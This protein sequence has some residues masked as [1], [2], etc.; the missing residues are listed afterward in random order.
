[1][2][3]PRAEWGL[4]MRTS[5]T[6]SR[7]N[8]RASRRIYD[9]LFSFA[10]RA[11][12]LSVVR[13]AVSGYSR[14]A[15]SPVAI[16]NS[17]PAGRKSDELSEE[18][19]SREASQSDRREWSNTSWQKFV[20]EVEGNYYR[21]SRVEKPSETRR[22]FLAAA[23]RPRTRR[24]GLLSSSPRGARSSVRAR[25]SATIQPTV[26]RRVRPANRVLPA[27]RPRTPRSIVIRVL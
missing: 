10:S 13:S 26:R 22:T 12:A 8:A 25:L 1:M 23:R 2:P 11:V 19:P 3:Q 21:E 24:R 27:A 14:I 16:P 6:L 4:R 9:C 15:R 7:T 5:S 18:N 17:R 20:R